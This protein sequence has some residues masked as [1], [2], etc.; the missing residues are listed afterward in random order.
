V[1]RKLVV[2]PRAKLDV[3]GHYVYLLGRNADAADRFRQS[4]KA[5]Q[6]RI[7]HDPRGCATLALPE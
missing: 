5:A 1:K 4:V 2:Q 6:K 3:V 7:R